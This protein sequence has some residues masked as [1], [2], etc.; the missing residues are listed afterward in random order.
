MY[1]YYKYICIYGKQF[2]SCIRLHMSITICYLYIIYMNS[3]FLEDRPRSNTSSFL[4]TPL[5]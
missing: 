2:T 4:S 5:L 3:D 1:A